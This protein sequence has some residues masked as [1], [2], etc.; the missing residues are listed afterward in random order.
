MAQKKSFTVIFL[1]CIHL[2][3]EN[4]Q[5]RNKNLKMFEEN[6]KKIIPNDS[7]FPTYYFH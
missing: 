4:C 3:V 5:K 2:K 7:L 6:Q 1:I